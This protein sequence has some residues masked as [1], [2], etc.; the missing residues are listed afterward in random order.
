LHLQHEVESILTRQGAK[1]LERT[2][3]EVRFRAPLLF[4]PGRAYPSSLF[5][6]DDGRVGLDP[7]SGGMRVR[8]WLSTRRMALCWILLAVFLGFIVGTMA[9]TPW[10]VVAGV[11]SWL[12]MFGLTYIAQ[13]IRATTLFRSLREGG[14]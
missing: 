6:T 2:S 4:G 8:Y 5:L 1:I 14:G 12:W 7:V 3:T 11:L 10:G 13:R 9:S